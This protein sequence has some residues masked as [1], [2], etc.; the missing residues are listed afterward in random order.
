MWLPDVITRRRQ[1]AI[2]AYTEALRIHP[3]T[4]WALVQRGR[5]YASENSSRRLAV[6]DF[7]R[8]TI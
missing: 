7:K 1:E 8:A 4:V 5:L 6:N 3:Q 2:D